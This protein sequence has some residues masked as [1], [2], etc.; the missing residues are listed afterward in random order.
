MTVYNGM[1][2]CPGGQ[3]APASKCP[4][5]DKHKCRYCPGYFKLY[6]NGKLVMHKRK[7]ERING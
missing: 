3:M 4:C 1:Y 5:C 7:T 2:R 6:P